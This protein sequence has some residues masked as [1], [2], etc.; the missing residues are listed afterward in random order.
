MVNAK[1]AEARAA[2]PQF[3]KDMANC[4][5]RRAGDPSS[6]QNLPATSE[7][8]PGDLAVIKGSK[9]QSGWSEWLVDDALRCSKFSM[10]G[11]QF[12]AYQWQRRSATG[13][14]V[15]ALGDLD[16]D[17]VP[18]HRF[19]QA[20]DCTAPSS[21]RIGPLLEQRAAFRGVQPAYPGQHV[22]E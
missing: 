4:S 1:S 15:V 11:P 9:Y 13:G 18:D 12:F 22:L 10:S 19:S 8:V 7:A 5:A 16:G 21:C 14:S 2:L 20:V 6:P 3:A 17:G